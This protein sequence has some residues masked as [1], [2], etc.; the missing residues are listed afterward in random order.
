MRASMK[1]LIALSLL[2]GSIGYGAVA[3]AQPSDGHDHGHDHAGHGGPP[4]MAPLGGPPG[5]VIPRAGMPAGHPA[6]HEAAAAHDEHAEHGEGHEGHHAPGE[7]NWIYGLLGEHDSAEKSILFRPHGMPVPFLANILNFGLLIGLFVYFGR[8]PLAEALVKRKV[9]LTRDI[10]DA[11]V[12]RE[13][14]E[15]RLAE[16]QAQLD[17]I[18]QESARIRADYAEQGKH[19]KERIV[20]EA[21]ERR[22]RMKRDAEFLLEQETKMLRQRLTA[23]TVENA[24]NQAQAL[25]AQRL[26]AQD[27]ERLAQ[28]YLQQLGALPLSDRGVA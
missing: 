26:T 12:V 20:R 1:K 2:A 25:I 13:K 17:Q 5:H 21:R 8:K 15:A 16:Y 28:E 18:E 9:D 11:R 24:T 3:F 10:E 7:I 27:Q 4:T 22:E 19:D 23:S 14:A 6:A